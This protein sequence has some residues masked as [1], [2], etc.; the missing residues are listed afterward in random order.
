MFRRVFKLLFCGR[1]KWNVGRYTYRLVRRG[2][3]RRNVLRWNN[4]D[5]SIIMRDKENLCDVLLFVVLPYDC[6]GEI[7]GKSI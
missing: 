2:T 4:N 1:L 7:T 5:C 6:L 3:M